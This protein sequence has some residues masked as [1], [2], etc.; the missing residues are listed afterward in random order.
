M[1]DVIVFEKCFCSYRLG[2][3]N[4]EITSKILPL[5]PHQRGGKTLLHVTPMKLLVCC[6][7]S[8]VS[9]YNVYGSTLDYPFTGL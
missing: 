6:Y 7:P 5:G 9:T 4:T 3:K 2:N 8:V 1:S